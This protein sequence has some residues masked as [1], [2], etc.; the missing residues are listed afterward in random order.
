MNEKKGHLSRRI[1][2]FVIVGAAALVLICVLLYFQ[3]WQAAGAEESQSSSTGSSSKIL[4]ADE[5]RDLLLDA[6][7]TDAQAD[8]FL[9]VKKEIVKSD[10]AIASCIGSKD[11]EGWYNVVTSTNRGFP[12]YN[13]AHD[14]PSV[15]T[16]T[17]IFKEDTIE[18]FMDYNGVKV[19]EAGTRKP[20]YHPWTTEMIIDAEQEL[21]RVSK[22]HAEEWYNTVFL[23]LKPGSPDWLSIE[24]E[25]NMDDITSTLYQDKAVVLDGDVVRIFYDLWLEPIDGDKKNNKSYETGIRIYGYFMQ[26]DGA[27]PALTKIVFENYVGL[28]D[29]TL[30]LK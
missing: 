7:M 30:I 5:Q 9:K 2:P 26:R 10:D 14:I 16:F 15:L 1:F 22:E 13:N 8:A 4:S 19:I 18:E 11:R 24:C 6:G 29:Y 27:V 20:G 23:G 12:V 17:V 3:P 28:E 21:E 25:N